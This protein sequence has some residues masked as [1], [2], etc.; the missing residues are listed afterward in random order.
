MNLHFAQEDI[1]KADLESEYILRLSY[2]GWA[3]ETP[4]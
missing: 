3:V 2:F 1:G 4:F